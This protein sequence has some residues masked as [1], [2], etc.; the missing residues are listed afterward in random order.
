[1]GEDIYICP[2]DVWPATSRSQIVQLGARASV[3]W[4][5]VSRRDLA[6]SYQI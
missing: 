2:A 4:G 6:L 3:C 1:M 5:V